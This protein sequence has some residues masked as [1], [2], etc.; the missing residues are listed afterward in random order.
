MF[1]GL[2][3]A[4]GWVRRIEHD[5]GQARLSLAHEP[6]ALDRVQ[7]GDSLSVSG[8]CLTAV[9]VT[10]DGFTA[11]VSAESLRCT[12]L[13]DL[14][15]GAR[16]NLEP[17]LRVGDRLGGHWVSGHVDGIGE[18][19]SERP[20]GDSRRLWLRAPKT[21]ARYI[22]GKGSICIDG[23]S[24]TV[25]QVDGCEFAVNV[26]PHSLAVTTLGEWRPGRRVNLEVDLIARYLERLLRA[27]DPRETS[28]T[29]E[30]L[31]RY[32]FAPKD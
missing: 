9:T 31:Q 8:C 3:K 24:L 32:G 19:L 27:G 20:E 29:R 18:L 6:G 10:G 13:G 1:T 12:V 5:A 4:V 22:A 23:V 14:A 7:A 28:L 30:L 25:N 17:A 15:E 11:D 16:V 26:I 21:L 2:V